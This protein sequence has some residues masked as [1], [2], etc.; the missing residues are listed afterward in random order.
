[1]P[2]HAAGARVFV[3]VDTNIL[4]SHLNFLERTMN[5]F[6][7]AATQARWVVAAAACLYNSCGVAVKAIMLH[8]P[9]L[10]SAACSRW[11]CINALSAAHAMAPYAMCSAC[12]MRGA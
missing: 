7:G 9:A 8:C 12:T 2:T 11:V 4:L 1:M 3:V 6:A 5:D 10:T